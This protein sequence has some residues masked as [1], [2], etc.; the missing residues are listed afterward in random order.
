MSSGDLNITRIFSSRY[1]VEKCTFSLSGR[2]LA[3][4]FGDFS[5]RVFTIEADDHAH[6]D[7][8]IQLKG[9]IREHKSNVWCIS[10][11]PDSTL[12]C[13]CSSD[14]TARIWDVET[15]EQRFIFN[16][17]TDTIWCCSFAPEGDFVATGSSDK[18]VKLWNFDHGEVLYNLTEYEDAIDCIDFTMTKHN[19]MLLCTGCRDGTVKAWHIDI[20]TPS[21]VGQQMSPT[22]LILYKSTGGVVGFCKFIHRFGDQYNTSTANGCNDNSETSPLQK[23]SRENGMQASQCHDLLVTGGKNNDIIVWSVCDLLNALAGKTCVVN[24][25]TCSTEDQSSE[26]LKQTDEEVIQTEGKV[27]QSSSQPD[28][29]DIQLTLETAE[30][31]DSRD[32]ELDSNTSNGDDTVLHYVQD[33]TR[34]PIHCTGSDNNGRIA[35]DNSEWN[36]TPESILRGHSNIVWDCC[37]MRHRRH[38]VDSSSLQ[39]DAT[40]TGEKSIDILITCSSDRTLR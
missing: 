22:C 25:S 9:I 23:S 33:N 16:A 39:L 19:S 13:T 24:Q 5:V 2:L 31:A 3:T 28:E 26:H 37:S 32:S 17:H 10:F 40:T 15:L 38:T 1:S 36:I 7:I 21:S 12:L 29:T 30:T 27:I 8:S 34:D 14:K 20:T 35:S 11:S 4:C 6:S 18:T